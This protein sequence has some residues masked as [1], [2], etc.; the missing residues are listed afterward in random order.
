MLSAASL[1]LAGAPAAPAI[2]H[3]PPVHAAIHQDGLARLTDLT[4]RRI[5]LADQ[6]AAAKYG[7]SRPIDDP[8]RERQ[9]LDSVATLSRS[10][11]LA[12]KDGV[13]FFTAQIE[14]AKVVQ[15]GLYAHWKAHPEL[16][17]SERPELATEVRPRLDLLTTRILRQLK[18]TL[19][20]R[21][22]TAACRI[23]TGAGASEANSSL[24]AAMAA[25]S[26]HRRR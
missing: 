20:V 17:P 12:P 10:I 5:L 2:D 15:R 9:V 8:A 7:T 24:I 3:R 4:V 11:G 22:P 6:V 18:A 26:S 21:E 1:V 25:V 23:V 19:G 13:D 16:R 14:A